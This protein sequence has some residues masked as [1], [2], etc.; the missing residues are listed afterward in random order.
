M[1]ASTRRSVEGKSVQ[2]I[3]LPDNNCL[4]LRGI[5]FD[6][7]RIYFNGKP[8]QLLREEHF[9]IDGE[10]VITEQFYFP[11]AILEKWMFDNDAIGENGECCNIQINHP[12]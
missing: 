8:T 7:G 11:T 9:E 1:D 3:A 12:V 4:F 10:M 6:K 5:D 2:M